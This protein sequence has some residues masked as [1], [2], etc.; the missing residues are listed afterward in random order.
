MCA[1]IFGRER[2]EYRHYENMTDDLFERHQAAHAAH[3]SQRF[4]VPPTIR[5]DFNALGSIQ[6]RAGVNAQGVGYVTDNLLAFTGM[7]E[8]ISVYR[9]PGRRDGADAHGYPGRR[10]QLY[11][12]CCRRSW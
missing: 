6:E 2:H 3:F 1:D 5:H 11:P 8:E 12:A 7:I 4:N 10:N 9:L